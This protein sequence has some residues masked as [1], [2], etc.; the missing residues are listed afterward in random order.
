[1]R[2]TVTTAGIVVCLTAALAILG[3]CESVQSAVE[4]GE[5]STE[6]LANSAGGTGASGQN[7]GGA[8]GVL[9]P[10]PGIN[11]DSPKSTPEAIR[12]AYEKFTSED[13]RSAGNCVT[14]F[15]KMAGI[16]G[17]SYGEPPMTNPRRVMDNADPKWLTGWEALESR[18]ETVLQTIAKLGPN[19]RQWRSARSSRICT[20]RTVPSNR[21]RAAG[22]SVWVR[23]RGTV[24]T[25]L[26]GV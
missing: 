19:S 13:C 16:D 22:E 1:M 25:L 23:V 6:D 7:P 21:R 17:S 3:G 9:S 5:V 2:T 18:R 20:R 12:K 15:R 4:D 8:G 14:P 26:A 11:P 24:S 10:V